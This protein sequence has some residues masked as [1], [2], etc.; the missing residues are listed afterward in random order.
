MIHPVITLLDIFTYSCDR[1]SNCVSNCVQANVFPGDDSENR[2]H[3]KDENGTEYQ[4]GG[5][6][7]FGKGNFSELFKSIEDY[8]KS[9]EAKQSAAVQQS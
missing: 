1:K 6:G 5:C 4:K 7:G 8:E 9:L 3:E 2:V